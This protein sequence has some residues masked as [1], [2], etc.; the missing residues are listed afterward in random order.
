MVG[1]GER[2]DDCAGLLS[3]GSLGKLARPREA[4]MASAQLGV[5]PRVEVSGAQHH[6][7]SRG[8]SPRR[9][10]T[11][12]RGWWC[13]RRRRGSPGASRTP[14]APRPRPARRAGRR[15]DCPA[16][17]RAA[18]RARARLRARSPRTARVSLESERAS[19][20]RHGAEKNEAGGRRKQVR[21]HIQDAI[22]GGER[23]AATTSSTRAATMRRGGP[24][25]RTRATIPATAV[26]QA[27]PASD[28]SMPQR[29]ESRPVSIVALSSRCRVYGDA[30]TTDEWERPTR[31]QPG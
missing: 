23:D 1:G 15:D 26:T 21:R 2:V 29:S 14:R 10:G 8:A 11:R 27:T 22:A 7:I 3:L 5:V 4:G 9:R 24:G 19:R 13:P 18:R 16:R 20:R 6:E 28:G 25:V 12:A 30:V 31:R 17:S